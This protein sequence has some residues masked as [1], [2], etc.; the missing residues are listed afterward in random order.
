MALWWWGC[1]AFFLAQGASGEEPLVAG[2]F[3]H[4]AEIEAIVL[5]EYY[6]FDGEGQCRWEYASTLEKRKTEAFALEGTYSQGEVFLVARFIKK[7]GD[8]VEQ[9]FERTSEE[10]LTLIATKTMRGDTVVDQYRPPQGT[11]FR[12]QE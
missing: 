11:V 12:L 10:E 6:F 3:F 8:L 5:E 9:R 2:T 4:R 1:S 7:N